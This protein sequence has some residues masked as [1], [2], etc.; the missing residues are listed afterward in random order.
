MV[1]K[2]VSTNEAIQAGPN[3]TRLASSSET[4]GTQVR[5]ERPREATGRRQPC[6]GRGE[7]PHEK[8]PCST[9]TRVCGLSLRLCGLRLACGGPSARTRQANSFWRR[10]VGPSG[11]L[12]SEGKLKAFPVLLNRP[13][14]VDKAIFFLTR[15]NLCPGSAGLGEAPRGQT[16][17]SWTPQHSGQHRA[18]RPIS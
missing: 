2:E 10:S 9:V 3:P 18:A 7:R 12:S 16:P 5:G 6:A 15:D 13:D 14:D 8:G 1:F 17:P 11:K 4:V